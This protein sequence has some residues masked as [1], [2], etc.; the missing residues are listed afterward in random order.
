MYV[1]GV[2]VT[3]GMLAYKSGVFAPSNEDCNFH[4]LYYYALAI[5]GYGMENGTDYWILKPSWGTNFGN[6]G[7]IK[8][9]RGINSCGIGTMALAPQV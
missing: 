4:S 8:M 7:Y 3:K 2:T 1:S 6:N 5:V 9:I